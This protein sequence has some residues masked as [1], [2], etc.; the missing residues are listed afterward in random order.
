MSNCSIWPIDKTLSG[1]TIPDQGR[2]R[3]D[4]NERV[5]C[6]PQSSSITGASLWDGLESYLGYSLGGE[7]LPLRRNTIGVF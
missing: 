5:L 3:S 6:I 2:P 7:V 4:G 1:A